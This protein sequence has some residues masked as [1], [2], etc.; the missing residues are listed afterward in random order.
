MLPRA[1]LRYILAAG[2]TQHIP[3]DAIKLTKVESMK[4]AV[5]ARSCVLRMSLAVVAAAYRAQTKYLGG[6]HVVCKVHF[7]LIFSNGLYF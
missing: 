1:A 6:W 7:S 4:M 2:Q 3:T 5:G